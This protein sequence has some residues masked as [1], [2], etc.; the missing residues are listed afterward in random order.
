MEE[1]QLQSGCPHIAYLCN[2]DLN[3]SLR[4]SGGPFSGLPLHIRG[5]LFVWIALTFLGH[6]GVD[7][8]L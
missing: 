1:G 4:L 3:S 5:R 7:H 6:S 8:D 2:L